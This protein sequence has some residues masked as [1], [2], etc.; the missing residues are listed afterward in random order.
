LADQR[1]SA[2]MDYANHAVISAALALLREAMTREGLV[3]CRSA[4]PQT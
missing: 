3:N 4:C 2:G 1:E